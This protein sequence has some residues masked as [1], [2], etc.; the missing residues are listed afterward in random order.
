MLKELLML[1]VQIFQPDVLNTS[2]GRRQ[3]LS[4][5]SGAA[6]Y[7][8]YE[9]LE[10]LPKVSA[11]PKPNR[12]FEIASVDR[13]TVKVPFR[14]IPHRA[15]SRE[16]PHWM[17]SEIC[18]VKLKSG[19][20]GH[21]ETMLYYTYGATE[22]SDVARAIGKNAV[23]IMWDDEL[24]AGL[25]MALFD[26][27]GKSCEV[28]VHALLGTQ[29]TSETPLAWWNID[30]SPKDM[31]AECAEA[32]RQGYRAYKT[33]GRPWFDVWAMCE[34]TAKAVPDDFH[35]A[36]DFNDTLL[37]AERGIP[38]LKEL[39]E[40]P[41]M[42]FWETPISQD[43]IAGN[44]AIRKATRVP[45]A[46]HYGN[47]DAI[48]ALK[49]EICDGFVI[50]GGASRVR[51][52]GTVSAMADKPFW[53][54]IVG[55]GITATWSKHFGAVLSHAKWP[56]VN[57]HQ[58]YQHQLLTEPVKVDN[59]MS[60]IPTGPGLGCEIDW[61]AVE[62]YRVRKPVRRPE[63]PRLIETTWPDGRRMYI[64]NN[65]K[66]NF[67][68]NIGRQGQMPYFERGVDTTLLPNDGSTRWKELYAS[69][70]KGPVLFPA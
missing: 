7:A 64:A 57:C 69:A 68:L 30:T 2:I 44:Q 45:V 16:I 4:W 1:N 24:G 33:K 47:P 50:G 42:T 10:G 6:A 54:Q 14:E 66:V 55:T 49:N 26:A 29:L 61:D 5:A 51:N 36:L 46:M 70:R 19:H 8:G 22:D 65:G 13:V 41:Q 37:T 23:E 32:Y 15:M 40:F 20:V 31:A 63:P 17:Y 12:S 60:A 35:V 25:Q 67:M 18:S 58:L 27:V 62:K 59:G 34:E 3:F 53:L 11:A 28:P 9:L 38:I 56:A 43:D 39:A 21:G 52:R 48:V